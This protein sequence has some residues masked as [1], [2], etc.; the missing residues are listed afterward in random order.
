M[1]N[2]P[3]M[4]T[5]P[6][7]QIQLG[8]Q[9]VC[10]LVIFLVGVLLL[11]LKTPLPLVELPD[12][13]NLDPAALKSETTVHVMWGALCALLGIIIFNVGLTKGLI[14]LGKDAGARLPLTFRSI[15]MTPGEPGCDKEDG[16]LPDLYGE[17]V[18]KCLVAMFAWLLGFGA[19]CAEPALNTL[20]MTVEKLTKGKFKRSM[21]IGAVSLGVA[22][23]ITIGVL[24][25]IYDWNLITGILLPAY[26][27]ALT[28]TAL[29]S[30]EYICVAWDSAGVTTGPI[31]VPLVVSMGLGLSD[32]MVRPDGSHPEGFG[33]LACASVSPIIS[34]LATGLWVNGIN[35]GKKTPAPLPATQELASPSAEQRISRLQAMA[36]ANADAPLASF[37]A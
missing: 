11:L 25:M 20:G 34:V 33:I 7:E 31:T 17:T 4:K 37:S 2:V 12:P 3:L 23:G 15:D 30:E 29:S 13:N 32:A 16:S 21:L 36:T 24:R 26:A 22:T 35:I 19:T 8:L 18:G 14:Q 1:P 27:V 6:F 28:L 5:V 10:P 9:A